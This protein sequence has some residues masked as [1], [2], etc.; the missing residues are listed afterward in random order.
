MQTST[1]LFPAFGIELLHHY[2]YISNYYLLF[3]LKRQKD[4]KNENKS[5]S[6]VFTQH[7]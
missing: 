7:K 3:G 5:H 2:A 4:L 1:L 6:Q